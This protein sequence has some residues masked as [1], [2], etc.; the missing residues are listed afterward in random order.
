MVCR[1]SDKCYC[2]SLEHLTHPATPL[3]VHRGTSEAECTYGDTGASTSTQRRGSVLQSS[4]QPG[5]VSLRAP[6]AQ[7]GFLLFPFTGVMTQYSACTPNSVHAPASG[8]NQAATCLLTFKRPTVT[9]DNIRGLPEI[10][11]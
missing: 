7:T 8:R 1:V 4:S 3:C 6:P 2:V 11:S 10:Y 9:W 5:L